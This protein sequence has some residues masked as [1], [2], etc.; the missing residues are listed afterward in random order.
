MSGQ[1]AKSPKV[2][3]GFSIYKKGPAP[4][5][6]FGSMVDSDNYKI[7]SDTKMSG[8]GGSM[9]FDEKLP[10][11]NFHSQ[12]GS[13]VMD[14]AQSR[15]GYYMGSTIMEKTK[16][17]SQKSIS[18]MALNMSPLQSQTNITTPSNKKDTKGFSYQSLQAKVFQNN[19]GFK[20]L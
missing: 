9:L 19:K 4:P 3:S 18:S 16:T 8:L 11:K 20:P 12:P 6:R 17:T 15:Q 7:E 13:H 10:Q 5:P 1:A 14:F 2:T